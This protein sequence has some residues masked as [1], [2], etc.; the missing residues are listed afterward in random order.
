MRM[1]WTAVALLALCGCDSGSTGATGERRPR[2][3]EA[4]TSALERGRYLVGLMDCGGCHSPRPGENSLSGGGLGFEV[5]GLGVFWPPNLT[6]HPTAGLG[7][8]SEADMIA[9][10]RT[11]KRPDGRELAPAMP[12][13][14]YAGLTDDDAHAVAVYLKSLPPSDNKV[15]SPTQAAQAKSPFLTIKAPN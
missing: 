1:M 5:P 14:A 13:P 9:A 11:G 2:Q 15:P 7:R 3:S 10:I 6:A 8:W 12:W 4:N